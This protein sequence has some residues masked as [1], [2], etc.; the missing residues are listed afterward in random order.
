VPS[1]GGR[2]VP[3]IAF[4]AS[5]DISPY[6]VVTDGSIQFYGGTSVAAPVFAGILT[7]INQYMVENHALLKPG[8]GNINPALYEL[9]QIAPAAFHDV[10][11][12]NNIVPC[13]PGSPN[14]VGN[15]N[16]VGS[17]GYAAGP[18]YDRVTGLGSVDAYA[19]ATSWLTRVLR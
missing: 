11:L 10:T 14:C 3:D 17:M 15:V 2:D 9:A 12:G 6:Y 13:E 19:L 5:A 8:L 1:G 18:G 16:G 4:S 7:L